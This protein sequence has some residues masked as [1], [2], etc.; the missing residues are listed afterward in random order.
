MCSFISKLGDFEQKPAQLNPVSPNDVERFENHRATGS[1][2]LVT[3]RRDSRT[4]GAATPPDFQQVPCMSP[5]AAEL[6]EYLTKIFVLRG[7]SP[8]IRA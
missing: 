1:R 6:V 5:E 4:E 8:K 2:W 3:F 7:N